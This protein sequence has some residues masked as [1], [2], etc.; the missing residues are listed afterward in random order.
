MVNKDDLTASRALFELQE[1]D[2]EA[3]C[4]ESILSR[5][6]AYFHEGRI[7]N[8][9]IDGDVL[10]AECE[11]TLPENY[12][13]SA[14]IESGE[15]KVE[16]SCPYQGEVCKH[17]IALLYTWVNNSEIFV[18]IEEIVT[19]LKSKSKTDLVKIITRMIC[20]D[21]NVLQSLDLRPR[22][23]SI[24]AADPQVYERQIKAAIS[25]Y[26]R[27][28]GYW[29]YYHMDELIE[30]IER[31]KESAE[32]YI[33]NDEYENAIAVLKPLIYNAIETEG[34]SDDS[35]GMLG[36]FIDECFE[37]YSECLDH[38]LRDKNGRESFIGEM[39]N[40]YLEE[41]YGFS[42]AITDL[43]WKH[44][45]PE[46][47]DYIEKI[48]IEKM[49]E[50]PVAYPVST[51]D[52]DSEAHHMA[53]QR[54]KVVE[55]LLGLY[56][57]QDQSERSLELLTRERFLGNNIFT[58][59][60]RLEDSG[61]TDDA[62]RYCLEGI[63]KCEKYER[64]RVKEK[65]ASLYEVKGMDTDALNIYL[66]DF[67]EHASLESY[68]TIKSVS[69]KLN[70]WPKIQ[71]KLLAHVE[72]TGPAWLLLDIF[73]EEDELESAIKLVKS[74]FPHS[75]DSIVKVA[76]IAEESRIEDAL[77]LYKMIVKEFTGRTGRDAY[78]QAVKYCKIVK[79][80]YKKSGK[81]TEWGEYIEKIRVE[82][83]RKKTLLEEFAKL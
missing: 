4:S 46:D 41:D 34:D 59:I 74:K 47:Y 8:P 77:D 43:I 48:A 69:K 52:E 3:L 1:K 14:K 65:L 82:N 22:K 30:K 29:D 16:C 24:T 44:S 51:Y 39:I 40:L 15:I 81:V 60:N 79:L 26:P 71:P 2:I 32:R 17:A 27:R 57:L 45:K 78:K 18:N 33:Q 80:L 50:F 6:S 66:N 72:H 58:L 21:P 49:K 42:D 54:E 10:R 61:K 25:S 5:G 31:F 7:V 11:G 53:Y 75:T 28:E 9:I 36:E 70:R 35:D 55:F 62:I 38:T 64:N 76:R 23:K 37:I 13:V 83:K 67:F 73:I 19:L 12:R 20:K 68:K 63:E 56:E